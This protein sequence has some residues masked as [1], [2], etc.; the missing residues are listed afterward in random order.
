MT[1]EIERIKGVRTSG[2]SRGKCVQ[3]EEC[4]VRFALEL[5]VGIAR[6]GIL[7]LGESNLIKCQLQKPDYVFNH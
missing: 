1:F 5:F 7:K 3:R 4:I 6:K 2:C